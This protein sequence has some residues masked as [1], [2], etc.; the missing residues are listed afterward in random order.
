MCAR[1]DNNPRGFAF[2]TFVPP[3]RR[4]ALLVFAIIKRKAREPHTIKKALKQGRHCAPPVR[5][6]NNQM[7]APAYCFLQ[8]QEIGLKF[9]NYLVTFVEYRVKTNL[10]DI[11]PPYLVSSFFCRCLIQERE[12]PR[13]RL[14]RVWVTKQDDNFFRA[15]VAKKVHLG[16]LYY[17]SAEM[18]FCILGC[19]GHHINVRQVELGVVGGFLRHDWFRGYGNN[20]NGFNGC[21]CRM[22]R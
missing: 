13:K 19:T 8:L 7:V 21:R 22:R 17:G 5:V 10:G 9:L 16:K 15:M 11:E 2:K 18:P 20:H 14:T 3:E 1:E 6:D 12:L 4:G